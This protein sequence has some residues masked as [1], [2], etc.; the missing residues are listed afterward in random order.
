M[1]E[2]I[3]MLG[4]LQNVLCYLSGFMKNFRPGPPSDNK[5]QVPIKY[6]WDDIV[7]R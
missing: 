5:C 1:C 4:G 2:N 6:V 7:K 3:D